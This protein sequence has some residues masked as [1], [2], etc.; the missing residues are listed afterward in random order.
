MNH[1]L[2]W[3]QPWIVKILRKKY[4]YIAWGKHFSLQL[5]YIS[6][7]T[8]SSSSTSKLIMKQ[9]NFKKD[10][11]HISNLLVIIHSF[12]WYFLFES[13]LEA[14][15]TIYYETQSDPD[16]QWSHYESHDTVLSQKLSSHAPLRHVCHILEKIQSITVN[17]GWKQWFS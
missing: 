14:S 12:I 3:S 7:K 2:R 1:I 15:Y 16:L 6:V 17:L 4:W 8:L 9:R 5:I 10:N 13:M 11:V